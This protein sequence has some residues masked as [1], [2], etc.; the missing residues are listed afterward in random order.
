MERAAVERAEKALEME[1]A[2][3]SGRAEVLLE[4]EQVLAPWMEW[5]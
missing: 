5:M 3:D 2:A 4:M 1:E